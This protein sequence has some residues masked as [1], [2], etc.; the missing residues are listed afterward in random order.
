MRTIYFMHN[1]ETGTW[2]RT[3]S[4]QALSNW[5]NLTNEQRSFDDRE[6]RY[7]EVPDRVLLILKSE[8][9]EEDLTFIV[10][11]NKQ[12]GDVRVPPHD[13]LTQWHLMGGLPEVKNYIEEAMKKRYQLVG[14]QV[15]GDLSANW[16][17]A[18]C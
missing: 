12:K 9:V 1:G 7:A 17:G 10:L 11:H 18:L 15:I 16:H 14:F 13:A 3:T 8:E 6:G 2:E 5:I 4:D